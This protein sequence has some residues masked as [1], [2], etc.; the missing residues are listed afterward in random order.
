MYLLKGIHASAAPPA[1]AAT[2]AAVAA[3]TAAAARPSRAATG[4]TQSLPSSHHIPATSAPA[5]Y[6]TATCASVW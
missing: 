1:K 4:S 5:A 6:P 3:P 2:H